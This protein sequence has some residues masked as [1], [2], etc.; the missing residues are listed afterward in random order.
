MAHRI[1]VSDYCTAITGG[2]IVVIV[3]P[4]TTAKSISSTTVLLESVTEPMLS[5]RCKYN[6]TMQKN[7]TTQKSNIMQKTLHNAST[8]TCYIVQKNN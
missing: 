8:A 1:G 4:M 2:P 6:R 7:Y 5:N 3:A